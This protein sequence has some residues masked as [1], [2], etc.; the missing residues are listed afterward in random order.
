MKSKRTKL[1]VDTW[2]SLLLVCSNIA[3]LK[4]KAKKNHNNV[5]LL[6]Y[7]TMSYVIRPL[8]TTNSC[9]ITTQYKHRVTTESAITLILSRS[10]SFVVII[11]H[12]RRFVCVY[13][14]HILCTQWL[15]WNNCSKKKNRFQSVYSVVPQ[16]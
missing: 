16:M 2:D 4:L 11:K 6:I 10:K 9:S 1:Q 3:V 15:S 7:W 14:I 13:I 12:T 5:R 8:T